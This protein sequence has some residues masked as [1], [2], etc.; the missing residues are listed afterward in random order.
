MSEPNSHLRAAGLA[1]ES[2]QE[3]GRCIMSVAG[4]SMSPFIRH[5]DRVTLVPVRDTCLK[6]GDVVL[7]ESPGGGFPLLHRIVRRRGDQFLIKGDRKIR[8]DGLF[9]RERI[10]ARAVFLK[11]GERRKRLDVRS[12][13]WVIALLSLFRYG[14]RAIAGGFN[15]PYVTDIHGPENS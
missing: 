13:N 10:R 3:N 15:T 6:I 11:R 1:A 7:V 12:L 8:P 14:I 2:I 4:M 5:G 9:H